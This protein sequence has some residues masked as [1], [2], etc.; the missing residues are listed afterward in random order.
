MYEAVAVRDSRSEAVHVG[1][2]QAILEVVEALSKLDSD[3]ASILERATHLLEKKLA[4]KAQLSIVGSEVAPLLAPGCYSIPNPPGSACELLITQLALPITAE[5]HLAESLEFLCRFLAQVLANSRLYGTLVDGAEK[6]RAIFDGSPEGI[7]VLDLDGPDGT[8]PIRECNRSFSEMNGY[9]SPADLRGK[10]ILA[11]SVGQALGEVTRD[12][13]L[14][15]VQADGVVRG[16]DTHR[17]PDGTEFPVDFSTRILQLGGKRCVLGID[18]DVSEDVRLRRIVDDLRQDIGRTFHTLTGTLLQVEAA[19]TPTIAALSPQ[20]AEG[21]VAPPIEVLWSEIAGES[22]AAAAVLRNL[23]GQSHQ[24]AI[25]RNA[26]SPDGWQALERHLAAF[27]DVDAPTIAREMLIPVIQ[28][29]A[30]EVLK[31]LGEV[32]KAHLSRL[33]LREARRQVARLELACC[34]VGI[35]VARDRVIDTDFLVR[36]IRERVVTGRS[37]GGE[38]E[39]CSLLGMVKDAMS[40]LA[41][42]AAYR[43]L[44]IKLN[45]AQE[46]VVHVVRHD[47]VRC[48]NN[49]LHN[50]IKYSWYRPGTNS[51]IDVAIDTSGREA[52]LTIQDYG[53]P[54]HADELEDSRV[55]E[56]GYRGRLASDRGRIGT[57]IGL[58]DSRDV[59]RRF[60]GDVTLESR[61]ASKETRAEDMSGP[62][63]KTATLRLPLA[64]GA[65]A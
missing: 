56:F 4:V 12:E 24:S 30:R 60:G 3:R 36:D 27:T 51:W 40:G 21:T 46:G 35:R 53:V 55:F 48:I 45:R 57:G 62:H 42:L 37:T 16:I 63:L 47:V 32:K 7:V 2:N 31:I 26:L 19:L 1:S 39:R 6:Y 9:A 13:Y 43:R 61:P 64:P 15:K 33:I 11:V 59:A 49:L 65:R 44:D 17:R 22:S 18:R 5:H 10:D 50:A 54:V 23:V 52:L 28:L 8:W 41:Q 58:F 38:Q 20:N 14:K 29:R 34:C 25:G